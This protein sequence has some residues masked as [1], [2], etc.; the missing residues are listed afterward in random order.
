MGDDAIERKTLT[1]CH[2]YPL[3]G[4]TCLCKHFQ[5][6]HWLQKSSRQKVWK[7]FTTLKPNGFWCLHLSKVLFEYK[8]LVINM[9]D[10][11]AMNSKSWIIKWDATC[12]YDIIMGLT[13]ALPMLEVVKNFSNLWPKVPIHWFAI[14][15]HLSYYLHLVI[16]IKCMQTY[17]RGMITP[18]FRF[19]MTWCNWWATAKSCIQWPWMIGCLQCN[20]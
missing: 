13:Y 6:Y 10:D 9:I 5:A 17:W 16:C 1:I 18:N 20:M 2:R 12:D 11:D 19:S 15:W 3:E 4:T 8:A 7:S 14:L